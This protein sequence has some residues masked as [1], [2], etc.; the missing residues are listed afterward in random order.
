[1]SMLTGD[2]PETAS[3]IGKEVGL[4]PRD[5]EALSKETADSLVKTAAQFDKMS[6]DEIDGMPSLPL[7]IARCAPETKTRMIRAIH[8]YALVKP[9]YKSRCQTNLFDQTW[10][11]CGNDWRWGQRCAE[12]Q[13]C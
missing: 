5:P 10:W 4:V 8:R 12:S 13:N 6:D 11:V 9:V 3:A 7:I 1:M 2:H